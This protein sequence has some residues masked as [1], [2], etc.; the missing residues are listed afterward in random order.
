MKTLKDLPSFFGFIR[1]KDIEAQFRKYI[2]KIENIGHHTTIK[3]K[4]NH[5][6]LFEEFLYHY[7]NF[8]KTPIEMEN[9][10]KTMGIN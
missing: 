5:Y 9:A 8:N 10:G 1:K 2:S 6:M 3:I 4:K 7:P